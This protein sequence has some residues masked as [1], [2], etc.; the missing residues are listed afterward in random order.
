VFFFFFFKASLN[1]INLIS[2][3][4]RKKPALQLYHKSSVQ[5]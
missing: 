5:V 4:V 1:Y 2:I 3:H